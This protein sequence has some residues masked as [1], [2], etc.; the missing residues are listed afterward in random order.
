VDRV[1]P[2]RHRRPT[3]FAA[4]AKLLLIAKKLPLSHDQRIGHSPGGV[5]NLKV[6][7][8][9]GTPVARGP[10]ASIGTCRTSGARLT[11]RNLLF[12]YPAKV[13]HPELLAPSGRVNSPTPQQLQVRPACSPLH[14]GGN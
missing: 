8:Q 4:H 12:Y 9:N 10:V 7:L 2:V 6:A 3:S 11:A 1:Q 14:A 13:T 5:N